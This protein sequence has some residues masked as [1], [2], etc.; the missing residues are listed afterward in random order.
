[1]LKRLSMNTSLRDARIFD[2]EFD[3]TTTDKCIN[4]M[5]AF[6]DNAEFTR[7]PKVKEEPTEENNSDSGD[8]LSDFPPPAPN[9]TLK[10][11][12]FDA[13]DINFNISQE[14]LEK[15]HVK[16]EFDDNTNSSTNSSSKF[17]KSEKATIFKR[18]APYVKREVEPKDSLIATN[19]SVP[20]K[21]KREFE[22]D[23]AILT[24]RQKQINYGKNTIGYDNYVKSVPRMDRKP[25]DP[26]TP[27]KYV[28]YSR[29]AWDGL[30]KQWRLKLHKYDP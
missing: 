10:L 13:D 29:R 20:K 19:S 17:G 16:A 26:T 9:I 3:D 8:S 25:D 6:C 28:K 5:D 23:T 22:N 30:I 18:E 2:S 21:Q 1:M 27:N 12:P 11:E 4:L 24:R 14:Q 7:I 15:I